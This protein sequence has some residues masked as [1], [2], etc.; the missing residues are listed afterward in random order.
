MRKYRLSRKNQAMQRAK[1]KARQARRIE[2]LRNATPTWVDRK[3]LNRMARCRPYGMTI[4]HIVPL[5]HPNV[6]G[7]HVPWNLQYLSDVENY[8]KHNQ[9]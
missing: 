8:R 1:R 5:Q 4:D 7:L 3:A 9:F 6:C 2:A